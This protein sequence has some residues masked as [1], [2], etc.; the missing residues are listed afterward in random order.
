[1]HKVRLVHAEGWLSPGKALVSSFHL[2]NELLAFF[3]Y[4]IFI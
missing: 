2:Q 3:T 1:M 4:I